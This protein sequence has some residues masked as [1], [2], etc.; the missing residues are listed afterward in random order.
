MGWGACDRFGDRQV[1][2]NIR[3]S[4]PRAGRPNIISSAWSQSIENTF[5]CLVVNRKPWQKRWCFHSSGTFTAI[6]G[7]TKPLRGDQDQTW[8]Q[9]WGSTFSKLTKFLFWGTFSSKVPRQKE[10]S[11]PNE[12]LFPNPDPKTETWSSLYSCRVALEQRSCRVGEKFLIW[13]T[14]FLLPRN[15]TTKSSSK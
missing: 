3:I 7:S 5:L 12:E 8:P 13:G 10:L 4:P 14:K 6:F 9:G 15:F 1:L 2:C 11:S